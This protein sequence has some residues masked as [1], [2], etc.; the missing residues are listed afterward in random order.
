MNA[1]LNTDTHTLLFQYPQFWCTAEKQSKKSEMLGLSS[2]KQTQK[3]FANISS[4][5]S[6]TAEV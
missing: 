4:W 1:H 3:S 2:L 6:N 5:D